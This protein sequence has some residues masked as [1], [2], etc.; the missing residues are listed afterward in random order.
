MQE[1]HNKKYLPLVLLLIPSCAFSEVKY[2]ESK[3]DFSNG[4][5]YEL[6]ISTTKNKPAL[7]LISCYPQNKLNVQLATLR[8]MFPDS[9]NNAGMGISITY[10]FDKT[11]NAITSDWFMNLMKYKNTWHL[12]DKAVFIRNA[13]KSD[14]LNMRLNKTNDIFKFEL[15]ESNAHLNKILKMCSK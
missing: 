3:D 11:E 5:I 8:T 1:K 13:I 2:L 10:K 9:S 12:G 7:L 6:K 15:K 4:T 14:W